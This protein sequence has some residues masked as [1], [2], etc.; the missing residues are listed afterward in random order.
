MLICATISVE[1][2]VTKSSPDEVK[3]GPLTNIPGEE[4]TSFKEGNDIHL[5][6]HVVLDVIPGPS[7][8]GYL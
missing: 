7:Y 1:S 5:L 3:Y 2:Q 6:L 4:G 8:D